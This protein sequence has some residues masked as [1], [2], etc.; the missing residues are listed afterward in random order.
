MSEKVILN[1]GKLL[2][3]SLVRSTLTIEDCEDGIWA[4]CGDFAFG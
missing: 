2:F 3:F 1:L 4:A